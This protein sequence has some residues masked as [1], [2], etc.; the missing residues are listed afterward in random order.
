MELG[1]QGLPDSESAP[2]EHAS[3]ALLASHRRA[4]MGYEF[5]GSAVAM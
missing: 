4:S 5:C 1:S 2:E 3:P